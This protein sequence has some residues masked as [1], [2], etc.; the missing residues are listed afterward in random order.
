MLT[1]FSADG[2]VQYFDRPDSRVIKGR[3]FHDKACA[4]KIQR[5]GRKGSLR[6]GLA[7]CAQRSEKAFDD[8]CDPEAAG[9]QEKARK[10][11][12][13]DREGG[14]RPGSFIVFVARP[15]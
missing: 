7:G 12:Q 2:R 8:D 14:S 6:S 3:P 13:K 4:D 1:M 11:Q 15:E 5:T 10:T 9:A